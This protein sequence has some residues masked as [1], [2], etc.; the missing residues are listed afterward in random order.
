MRTSGV[1]MLWVISRMMLRPLTFS[2]LT[3]NTVSPYF[4]LMSSSLM[5]RPTAVDL[6]PTVSLDTLSSRLYSLTRLFSV[7][8]LLRLESSS[9]FLLPKTSFVS[10]ISTATP[11]QMQT[12]PTGRNEKNDS[13]P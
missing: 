3:S 7:L 11:T 12:S 13:L 1:A 6:F 2:F 9:F 10:G 5:V 4:C 8:P